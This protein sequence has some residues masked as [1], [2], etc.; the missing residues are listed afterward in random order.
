M[1]GLRAWK[2]ERRQLRFAAGFALLAS[3]SAC[4]TR[5][6]IEVLE[7]QLRT[8]E[9]VIRTY[10][11]DLEKLRGDL[12]LSQ[13]EMD[14]MRTALAGQ[15]TQVAYEETSSSLARAQELVFNSLLT[16]AQNLDS[17]AGDERFHALFYPCDAQGEV[18]KLSGVIEL[19]A[20]DP[21]RPAADKTIGRWEYTAEQVRGLWHAGFLA[22]GYQIDETW[23][24]APIGSKVVLL[25][26]LTTTDG[27][28]FEATHTIS[29]V[30]QAGTGGEPEKLPSAPAAQAIQPASYE[31]PETRK[32]PDP[33]P[34]EMGTPQALPR[35]TRT[36]E[37]PSPAPAAVPRKEQ[38][39]VVPTK[40]ARPFPGA[41]K[42]SDNWTD[43][44]IPAWR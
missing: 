4:A 15:G 27:R 7:S 33:E 22:S 28:R 11:R 35:P 37:A 44:E 17:S 20:I 41:I 18:V 40:D 19:E 32:V 24:R 23:Q 31:V 5:G 8:Q 36:V 12:K 3:C 39:P 13:K 10:E 26:R 42:T 2:F 30:P 25:A 21:S 29:L 43:A 14:L 34:W 6:N 38:P 1:T 16:G 9:S